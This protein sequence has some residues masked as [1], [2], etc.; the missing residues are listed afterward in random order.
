MLMRLRGEAWRDVVHVCVKKHLEEGGE[1]PD[2]EIVIER[3]QFG[4]RVWV[5]VGPGPVERE[6]L[7]RMP[8]L[9]A[10]SGGWCRMRVDLARRRVME[11]WSE[12]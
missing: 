6:E 11:V 1:S 7:A 5:R 8:G 10:G 12:Q 4:R 3:W 2:R 9:V